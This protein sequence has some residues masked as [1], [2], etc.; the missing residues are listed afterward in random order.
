VQGGEVEGSL[1]LV[2]RGGGTVFD[3]GLPLVVW[4]FVF[5]SVRQGKYKKCMSKHTQ[6]HNIALEPHWVSQEYTN[7]PS[8]VAT[9]DINGNL[10]GPI[11]MANILVHNINLLL[12][13]SPVEGLEYANILFHLHQ[14]YPLS[15]H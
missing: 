2:W 9:L 1:P 14:F 3:V 12:V 15:P 10:W 6:V 7:I 5:V 8:I 4:V 13:G 11:N